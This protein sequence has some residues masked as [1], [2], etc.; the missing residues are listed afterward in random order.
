LGGKPA[1]DPH[2]GKKVL[3]PILILAKSPAPDPHF[4]IKWGRHFHSVN[5]RCKNMCIC[6]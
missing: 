5:A 4:G 3:P 6:V 1:P 2:L